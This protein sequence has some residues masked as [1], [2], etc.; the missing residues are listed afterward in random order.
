MYL[1]RI[2]HIWIKNEPMVSQLWN[3]TCYQPQNK[4][5]ILYFVMV[6]LMFTFMT[7]LKMFIN[8]KTMR[9][10]GMIMHLYFSEGTIS[11]VS[12]IMCKIILRCCYD[13]FVNIIEIN[14]N[15]KWV[16]NFSCSNIV[17]GSKMITWRFIFEHTHGIKIKYTCFSLGIFG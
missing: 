2:K 15:Q 12:F 1:Y 16:R 13:H 8:R 10:K 6:C 11:C 5:I 17:I 4:T 3:I 7:S 14:V 9:N